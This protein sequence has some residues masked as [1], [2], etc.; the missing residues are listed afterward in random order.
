MD[1]DQ[2]K[3]CGW[4]GNPREPLRHWAAYPPVEGLVKQIWDFINEDL[5]DAGIFV[6]PERA[7]MNLYNHGD[8]SWIHRDGNESEDWTVVLFL[9]EQWHY[10]WGGDF[11]II[12]DNG[13]DIIASFLA[14][15]GRFVAFRS[16]LLHGARPVSRDAPFPRFGI[17][18][19][20]KHDS[21]SSRLSSVGLSTIHSAL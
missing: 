10:N 19:Q 4:T 16:N 12:H 7:I 18:F 15:P 2:W 14:T 21:N 11:T 13:E 9:N 6:T 20:C 1:S 17:A 5:E 8:N 3:F